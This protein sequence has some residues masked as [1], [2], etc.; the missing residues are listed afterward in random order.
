MLKDLEWENLQT[1]R[2]RSGLVLFYKIIKGVVK[3]RKEDLDMEWNMNKT[4]K[5]NFFKV[6]T[7]KASTTTFQNSFIS[8]TIPQWND[9]SKDTVECLTVSAFKKAIQHIL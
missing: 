9:L 3:L 4:R 2:K 7:L 1:R 5:K 6:K 8:T